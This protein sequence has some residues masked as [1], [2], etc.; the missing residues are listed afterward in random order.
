MKL[1]MIKLDDYIT[2]IFLDF[3]GVIKDSVEVKSAAFEKIF[4]PFGEDIARRVKEHHEVNCGISRFIKLPI[5]LEWANQQGSESI[6]DEYAKKFS[7]LVV[8]K[9]IRS[10]W[11]PG[12]LEFMNSNLHK[13]LFLITAT[14]Q[15]EIERIVGELGIRNMFKRIIGSPAK[16]KDTIKKMLNQYSIDPSNAL[17]IGDSINDYESALVNDVSFILRRTYLNKELQKELNCRMIDNFL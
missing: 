5:Y 6:I 12:I 13:K 9:V 4:S 1:I 10:D 2:T 11:V 14:P 8:Q 7:S 17:V 16:K 15:N 3:D